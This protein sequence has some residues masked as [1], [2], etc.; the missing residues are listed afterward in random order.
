LFV[1]GP[2]HL[3]VLALDALRQGSLVE[4]LVV[5]HCASSY[6]GLDAD[7]GVEIIEQI[8]LR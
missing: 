8:T 6:A 2:S 5:R 4:V 1:G 7:V 3:P